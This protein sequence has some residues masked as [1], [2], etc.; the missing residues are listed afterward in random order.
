MTK[1]LN[2]HLSKTISLKLNIITFM[3]VGLIAGPLH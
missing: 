1:H 3:K 2:Q